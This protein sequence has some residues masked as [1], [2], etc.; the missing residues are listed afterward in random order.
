MTDERRIERDRLIARAQ[1]MRRKIGQIFL[2]ID[3]WNRIRPP[4]EAPLDA[5][6]DGALVR[7]LEQA[8][9]VEMA[10]RGEQ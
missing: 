2:D 10:L 1:E 3:H 9:A 5:D 4:G 8:D 7:A 6:P